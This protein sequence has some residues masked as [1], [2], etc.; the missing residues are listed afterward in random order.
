MLPLH[1]A[2]NLKEHGDPELVQRRLP[3]F[4]CAP[5]LHG[6]LYTRRPCSRWRPQQDLNLHNPVTV[7]QFRK[8]G[9]YEGVVM[10]VLRGVEPRFPA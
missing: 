2:R 8:L 3:Q 1:H 7:P 4:G 5:H 9:R 6:I 10:V